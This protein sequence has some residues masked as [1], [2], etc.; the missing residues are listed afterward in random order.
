MDAI[1]AMDPYRVI[2]NKGKIPWHYSADFK[3]FK[4]MTMGRTLI[5][6]R[7][8][9]ESLPIPL[10][11]REIVVLTTDF[12]W[13]SVSLQNPAKAD[14][15]YYR[16]PTA[17]GIMDMFNPRDWPEAIVCGGAK[18]YSTLLPFCDNLWVT[19]I[20]EDFEGDAYMPPFEDLFPYSMIEFENKDFFV[21]WY[22]KNDP[23]PPVLFRI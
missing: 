7:N 2:G 23:D 6:G 19:H 18:T 5:M 3:W 20:C 12:N 14:K 1:A 15:V 10:K 21:V 16:H 9:Y 13:A 17:P 22:T 8:T 11:G 4:Q